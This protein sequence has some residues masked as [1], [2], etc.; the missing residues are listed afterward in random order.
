MLQGHLVLEM[1]QPVFFQD[2]ERTLKDHGAVSID[3]QQLQIAPGQSA[4]EVQEP[5]EVNSTTTTLQLCPSPGHQ[6]GAWDAPGNRQRQQG[7]QR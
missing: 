7:R 6:L 3:H 5:V 1:T 4:P 2:L